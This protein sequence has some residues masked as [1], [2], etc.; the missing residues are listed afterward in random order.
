MDRTAAASLFTWDGNETVIAYPK[1]KDLPITTSSFETATVVGLRKE[2]FRETV[3]TAKEPVSAM[4]VFH[5]H[6][7]P[8]PD[9]HAVLMTRPDA[10]TVSVSKIEVS[11]SHIEMSYRARLDDTDQLEPPV[12]QTLICR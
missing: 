1:R 10:K 2:R 6:K 8:A 5:T 4:E 7:K 12:I 11:E 9:T 3:A